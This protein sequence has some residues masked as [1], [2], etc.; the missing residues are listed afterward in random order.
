MEGLCHSYIWLIYDTTLYSISL[1]LSVAQVLPAP[2]FMS[3]DV[4]GMDR[5]GAA[6]RYRCPSN[7]C[8]APLLRR[9]TRGDRPS[10]GRVPSLARFGYE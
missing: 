1:N 9:P 2:G 6:G 5:R 8:E 3:E 7:T 4:S 10:W